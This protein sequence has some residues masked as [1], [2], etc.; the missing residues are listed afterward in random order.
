M[1]INMTTGGYPNIKTWMSGPTR[2]TLR[3]A[4]EGGQGWQGDSKADA[5]GGDAGTEM[6]GTTMTSVGWSYS[7]DREQYISNDKLA[8]ELI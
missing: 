1:G 3:P 7:T 6:V 5:G 2:G 8:D 4:K